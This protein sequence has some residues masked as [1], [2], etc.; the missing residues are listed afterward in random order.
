[1]QN[2]EDMFHE[3]K[4]DVIINSKIK[5]SKN[6]KNL[7]PNTNKKETQKLLAKKFKKLKHLKKNHQSNL[8][9]N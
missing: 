3:R 5:S 1:M 8:I 2:Q 6:T 4:L 7:S 9:I